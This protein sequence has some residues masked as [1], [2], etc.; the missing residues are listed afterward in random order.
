[1]TK[2]WQAHRRE[3]KQTGS[4]LTREEVQEDGEVN[5]AGTSS[6]FIQQTTL[7]YSTEKLDRLYP[8]MAL[9]E[10][11]WKDLPNIDAT[12]TT[13]TPG[14]PFEEVA[15]QDFMPSDKT[16]SAEEAEDQS[17]DE[18]GLTSPY[19]E[20]GATQIYIP[21]VCTSFFYP[22]N[23]LADAPFLGQHL[24]VWRA[25]SCF[26]LK[27]SIWMARYSIH[28]G[29]LSTQCFQLRMGPT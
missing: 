28:T 22:F 29:W 12:T 23:F 19:D 20:D 13:S 9:M 14:Q 18:V 6:I 25:T 15:R 16:S 17:Y 11:Y 21:N 27:L 24:T 2:Q 4:G 10:P 3:I 26:H 1:M 5:M 7:I 8:W